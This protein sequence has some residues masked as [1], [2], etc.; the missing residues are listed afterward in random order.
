M[1]RAARLENADLGWRR[2]RILAHRQ[3]V[4]VQQLG[5]HADAELL[6]Q[7][8]I[9]AM[10]HRD[11]DFGF[12]LG[13]NFSRPSPEPWCGRRRWGERDIDFAESFDLLV[14]QLLA[15]VAQVGDAQES[16]VIDECGAVNPLDESAFW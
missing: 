2:Q 16:E 8:R 1:H 6:D 11:G 10:V 12:E 15:Q 9:V 4:G 7:I 5:L 14:V 13:K 3:G